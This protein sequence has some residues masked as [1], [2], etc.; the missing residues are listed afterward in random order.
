MLRFDDSVH[1][2]RSDGVT[3][4]A[5]A[6]SFLHSSGHIPDLHCIGPNTQHFE[7]ASLRERAD[8]FHPRHLE[9]AYGLFENCADGYSEIAKKWF[10]QAA[11]NSA[12]DLL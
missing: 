4:V 6:N 7:G 9:S 11:G 12:V 2:G 3:T 1:A 10:F 5:I 8:R